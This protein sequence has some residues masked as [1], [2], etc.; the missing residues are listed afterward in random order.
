MTLAA[1][2]N[3]LEKQL[4]KEVLERKKEIHTAILALIAQKHHFQIGPPGTA[5]SLLVNRIVARIDGL[6]DE[7]YF[8]WLLTRYSTP[9][10]LF[11]MPNLPDLREGKY[12]RN[13]EGK[14]PV[15]R[16]V[17]LD[18]IFKGNSSILNANL[19][20]MN[21][22]KFMNGSD[23]P[24]IPLISVFSASNELPEGEE[25][26]ALWDRL[27][28]RHE[29]GP[30]Q[31]S[32]SFVKMLSKPFDP[33]PE[34]MVSLDDIYEAQAEVGRVALDDILFES[35]NNLRTQLRSEGIEPTERRWVE[36]IPII[37]AEAFLNGREVADIED[38]RPLMHVLW[39]NMD[40][41]K[42][43]TKY[44]LELA[45][46]IDKE[47]QELLD[48][49]KDIEKEFKKV[50]AD[51]DNPKAV[52]RQAVEAHGRLQ[53]VK[54]AIDELGKTAKEAGRKSEIL[55]DTKKRFLKFANQMMEQAFGQSGSGKVQF[56]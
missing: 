4:N 39:S 40:Q 52:A 11:G 24:N 54:A 16:V 46:P 1:K 42:K 38:M 51:A 3:D 56:D 25:L 35:L 23:D 2:F 9:E 26:D 37:Q 5:K 27:H 50:A 48:D 55:D 12:R 45:N 41:R 33:N 32:A 44:V 43:V 31:S 28:F 7:G 6:G 13:T 18:E 20:A 17:F 8:H 19:T 53:E 21:E 10:E 29:V 49:I 30:I 15:A 47:A 22:R 36:C 14:L 34:P